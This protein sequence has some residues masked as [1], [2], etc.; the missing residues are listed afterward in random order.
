MIKLWGRASAG[1]VQKVVWCLTELGIPFE[2]VD[3]GRGFGVTDQPAYLKM[4][5]NGL[6]PTFEDEDL[7]LWESNTIVR[8][9]CAKFPEGGLYLADL[10]RRADAERWMDWSTDP[11]RA[12]TR[13]VSKS[14]RRK[15]LGTQDLQALEDANRELSKNYKILDDALE[16]RSYLLGGQFTMADIPLGVLAYRWFVLPVDRPRLPNV[17]A[18]YTR[19]TERRAF[20]QSVMLPIV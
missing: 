5:P 14:S 3:A 2:R 18:W 4:N 8:Y 10:R 11:L 9:L 20:R 17:E 1:S 19:L 12:P 13:V 16:G 6:V 15:N 7:V